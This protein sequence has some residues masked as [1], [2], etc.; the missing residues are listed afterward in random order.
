MKTKK[1]Y[2]GFWSTNSANGKIR[3]SNKKELISNLKEL[4]KNC[5]GGT[6]LIQC[7]NPVY[8]LTIPVATGYKN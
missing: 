1:T 2:Y 3:S 4:C 5:G 8:G 7:G 6:W